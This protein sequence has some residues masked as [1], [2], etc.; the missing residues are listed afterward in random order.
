MNYKAEVKV[1]G[2]WNNN[3]IVLAGEEEAKAYGENLKSRWLLVTDT[4]ATPTED[5]VTDHYDSLTG[6][7][8]PVGAVALPSQIRKKG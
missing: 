6:L 2:E 7:L 8:T 3:R 1:S 4:R 5:P